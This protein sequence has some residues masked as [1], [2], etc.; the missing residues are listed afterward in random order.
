MPTAASTP[1]PRAPEADTGLTHQ[2]RLDAASDIATPARCHRAERGFGRMPE[3]WEPGVKE[4]LDRPVDED[5]DESDAGSSN[6][7]RSAPTPAS[8]ARFGRYARHVRHLIYARPSSCLSAR[9]S[10]E[11]YRRYPTSP[12]NSSPAVYWPC[13]RVMPASH[14][15]FA[16]NDAG[17]VKTSPTTPPLVQRPRRLT[18]LAPHQFCY[19]FAPQQDDDAHHTRLGCP[20]YAIHLLSPP[21]TSV[22]RRHVWWATRSRKHWTY[23]WS[24]R[25]IHA[26]D[27]ITTHNDVTTKLRPTTINQ[28][29]SA[30]GL[31]HVDSSSYTTQHAS[32]TPPPARMSGSP[33]KGKQLLDGVRI[34]LNK[35]HRAQSTDRRAAPPTDAVTSPKQRINANVSSK[36]EGGQFEMNGTRGIV[37]SSTT[38]TRPERLQRGLAT[39]QEGFTIPRDTCEATAHYTATSTDTSTTDTSSSTIPNSASTTLL[40]P[41]TSVPGTSTTDATSTTDSTTS[42]TDSATSTIKATTTK[43]P[44]ETVALIRTPALQSKLRRRHDTATCPNCQRR[45]K[46]STRGEIL[47]FIDELNDAV[48]G[49]KRMDGVEEVKDSEIIQAIFKVL[50]EVKQIAKNAPPVPNAASPFGTPA[51]RDFY[52][53]VSVDREAHILERRDGPVT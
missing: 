18:N 31:C 41:P 42:A 51:F 36:V 6:S 25:H 3:W 46:S 15:L 11:S 53:K 12:L 43:N 10:H 8:W 44:L 40:S 21:A 5:D 26:S 37:L 17:D 4:F 13:A 35:R 23:H 19:Q 28:P 52:N 32:C 50:E 33:M 30:S 39:V 2:R 24:A 48:K 34:A 9:S 29:R 22:R 49:V 7:F 45:A 38:P 16:S 20:C 1:S 14:H 47:A 27:D